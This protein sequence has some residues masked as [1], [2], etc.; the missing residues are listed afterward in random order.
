MEQMKS[1]PNELYGGSSLQIWRM[2]CQTV[3]VALK[4]QHGACNHGANHQS[5]K[6]ASSE[7]NTNTVPDFIKLIKNMFNLRNNRKHLTILKQLL[8]KIGFFFAQNILFPVK[9]Y[10]F[11]IPSSPKDGSSTFPISGD[12]KNVH[13]V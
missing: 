7:Q 13:W 5:E 10:V 6:W 8:H 3:S 9:L 12:T 11:L 4:H 2:A 1:N